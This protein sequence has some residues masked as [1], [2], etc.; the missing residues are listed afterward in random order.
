MIRRLS[1]LNNG[2]VAVGEGTEFLVNGSDKVA[3]YPR[4]QEVHKGSHCTTRSIRL[5]CYN[6]SCRYFSIWRSRGYRA[7]ACI[8]P[9][10]M[11]WIVSQGMPLIVAAY[12]ALNLGRRHSYFKLDAWD[13]PNT[14]LETWILVDFVW[15]PIFLWN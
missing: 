13:N 14:A 4:R 8:Q 6:A 1:Y 7:S 12:L 3:D 2:H 11:V 5:R 15:R 10:R 9:V